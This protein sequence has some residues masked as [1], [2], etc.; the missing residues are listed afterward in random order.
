MAEK[1]RLEGQDYDVDTLSEHGRAQLNS[2]Q[3]VD[4]RL[5]ELKGLHAALTR[6]KNSYMAELK[7]EI[8]AA[9]GGFVLGDD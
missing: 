1:I 4:S 6:A 7:Q 9:R 8:V 5:A 2:L 3:Y